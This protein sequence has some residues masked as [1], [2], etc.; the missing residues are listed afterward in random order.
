LAITVENGLAAK[1]PVVFIAA[2][3]RGEAPYLLEWIAYHRVL[4]I[5][6]FLLADNGGDDG[7]SEML[8]K[9]ERHKVIAR[10]DW[11][12]KQYF[13]LAFLQQ[14]IELGRMLDS[15]VFLID[16]DEFLRPL[17]GTLNIADLARSWMADPEIGAVAINWAI[18]GSSGRQNA[19]DG[20]VI[21]RFTRRAPQGFHL[22]KH[23]KSFVRPDR[24]A[25]PSNP[26]S[27]L[28]NAGRYINSAGEDVEWDKTISPNGIS[29]KVVW[30]N[31]RVDHFVVKSREEFERKRARGSA[32]SPST[33]DD[34][35]HEGYFRN[36]DHNEIEDPIPEA[37]VLRTKAE[38][39]KLRITLAG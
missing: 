35:R 28:L 4:G 12:G 16:V 34:R 31:I 37:L 38:L 27:V 8:Q 7:T 39:E 19:T 21:E 24:C 10:I 15:G 23:V 5:T 26:H 6:A 32:H 1:K 22:N 14:V 30:R 29:T 20:L 11:T 33:E 13:Q 25:G 3:V 2:A 9:L 36:H 17:D 18:Y